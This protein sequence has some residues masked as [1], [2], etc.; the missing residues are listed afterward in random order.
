M[1]NVFSTGSISSLNSDYEGGGGAGGSSRRAMAP[2]CEL[3]FE[4]R[5][6]LNSKLPKKKPY[7][8]QMRKNDYVVDLND[9][10]RYFMNESGGGGIGINSCLNP[11]PGGYNSSSTGRSQQ[12]LIKSLNC[13]DLNDENSDNLSNTFIYDTNN[14]NNGG[15]LNAPPTPTG[16]DSLSNQFMTHYDGATESTPTMM[17][18]NRRHSQDDLDDAYTLAT[19]KDGGKQLAGRQLGQSRGKGSAFKEN[20]GPTDANFPNHIFG[21]SVT[22]SSCTMITNGKANQA[23]YKRMTTHLDS[24]KLSSINSVNNN[25]SSS[26]LFLNKHQNNVNS[27]PIH[28]EQHRDLR[29]NNA[30]NLS[31]IEKAEVARKQNGQTDSKDDAKETMRKLRC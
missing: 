6:M 17:K 31:A 21:D 27:S 1:K 18:G 15:Q 20:N 23:T 10:N 9:Y 13:F 14:N 7:A 30:N 22:S 4:S 24:S 3:D 25:T 19:A 12:N 29:N 5:I 11:A 26:N 28:A 8:D 16:L 2:I